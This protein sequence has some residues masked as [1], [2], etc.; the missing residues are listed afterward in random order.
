ML[1]QS[2]ELFFFSYDNYLDFLISKGLLCLHYN[3]CYFNARY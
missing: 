1:N 3:Y 2:I